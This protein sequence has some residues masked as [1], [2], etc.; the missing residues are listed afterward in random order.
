MYRKFV[1]FK[2]RLLKNSSL[3]NLILVIALLLTYESIRGTISHEK[4]LNSEESLVISLD[5]HFPGGGATFSYEELME[6]VN[7][8]R[9]FSVFQDLL[10]FTGLNETELIARLRREKQHHFAIEHRFYSPHSARELALYY[11]HSVGYLWGNAVHNSIDLNEI[12]ISVENAPVLDYA[13]GSGSNCI[14]LAKRGIECIYFSLGWAELEFAE[15]RVKRHGLENLIHFV[16][17][18]THD[19]IS[20]YKFDPINCLQLGK[21]IPKLLGTIIA[22]D[23]FEHIPHYE[24]TARHLVSLLREGGILFEKSPFDSKASSSEEIHIKKS[25]PMEVALQGMARE[26][27]VGNSKM[28]MWTKKSE[29]LID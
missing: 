1:K 9:T 10:A 14:A 3:G 27:R 2:R 22:Q 21:T 5:T 8:P 17:P 15:F 6:E 20:G 29:S 23:V 26:G 12:P 19:E 4:E 28:V 13:G 18:Y 7:H 25:V 24:K 16:K 11:R